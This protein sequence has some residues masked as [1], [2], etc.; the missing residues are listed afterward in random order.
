MRI[1]DW[2]S[3]VCSSDLGSKPSQANHNHLSQCHQVHHRQARGLKRQNSLKMTRHLLDLAH[4]HRCGCRVQ[5][6]ASEPVSARKCQD[7]TRVV[8]GKSVTVRVDIG[9]GRILKKKNK[10]KIK[11][12]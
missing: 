12:T 6:T 1:S 8:Q 3:D 9:G 4:R 5:M 10:T 7:R 2:S 11:T